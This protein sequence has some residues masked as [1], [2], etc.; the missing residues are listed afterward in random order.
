[1]WPFSRKNADSE[2]DKFFKDILGFKPRR[3]ELYEV[4]LTH[5]SCSHVAQG[6]KVNNERLE[7]LGDAVLS[8]IVAEFLY[9][10][11]PDRGEG[12]L[13]ELRSKI[14]SREHLNRL[15][16]DIGLTPLI[17]YNKSSHGIFK[18]MGGN[19]FE[20]LLGAIYL[21]KGY[22]KTRDIVFHRI[23]NVYID[24]DCI[25]NQG[26][27][28]KSKLID[29]GQKSRHKVS[30]EVVRESYVKGN[31]GRREFESQ[32]II[33]NNRAE[34]GTGFSIKSS[35]Q[36]AAELAYKRIVADDTF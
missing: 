28:Y 29:W 35:E 33:D 25:E 6:H 12:F 22:N 3:L 19:A 8:S 32:V 24:I 26:W 17:H 21:D 30:F 4:A 23:F 7:Y 5:K 14:V 15:A 36:R 2:R 9:R 16:N 31:R 1:M 18:S 13:S 27:N 10:H 34:K 11:Y 20:A